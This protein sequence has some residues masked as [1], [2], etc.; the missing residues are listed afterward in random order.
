MAK[1]AK[2]WYTSTREAQQRWYE[3][4]ETERPQREKEGK[5]LK[6]LYQLIGMTK[7]E[8]AKNAGIC[9]KTLAKFERGQYIQRRKAIKASLINAIRFKLQ[10]VFMKS[11]YALNPNA[12]NGLL[13]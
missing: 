10:T 3:K 9:A 2:Q 5:Q 11:A 12:F 1:L 13:N 6:K 7:Q 8:L 4:L